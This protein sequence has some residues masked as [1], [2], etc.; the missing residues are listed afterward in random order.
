MSGYRT[1]T[2]AAMMGILAVAFGLGWINRDLYEALV[3]LVG[4][5]GLATLRS[6]VE[7]SGLQ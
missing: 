5:I 4:G 1:Y 3:G 7:K 2:S 6:G